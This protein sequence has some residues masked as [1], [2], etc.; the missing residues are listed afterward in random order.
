MDRSTTPGTDRSRALRDLLVVIAVVGFSFSLLVGTGVANALEG[1]LERTLGAAEDE[2]LLG[3]GLAALGLGVIAALRWREASDHVAARLAAEDRHQ[4][5]VEKI[6]A[7]TYTWNPSMG[8]DGT[9]VLYVSPQVEAILGFSVEDWTRDPELWK[10]QIH[11]DDRDAVLAESEHADRT[12]EPFAAEYRHRRPDGRYVWIHEEAL[13]VEHGPDGPTL[14][15]GVMYDVTERRRAEQRLREAEERYRTLVERVPAVTYVWDASHPDGRPM[16][17]VSPQ[18]EPLL[19]VE[20]EEWT[21]DAT[22]WSRNVHPDDLARVKREWN[23]ARERAV[24]FRAEYRIVRG[25]GSVAW[26]RDEAVPV[27]SD[28]EGMPTYQGVLLDITERKRAEERVREAEE[29]YRT[30]VEQLPAITYIED[31]SGRTT[32]ISPQIETMLG[33]APSEWVSSGDIWARQLHPDDRERVL[34]ADAEPYSPGQVFMVDYRIFAKDGRLVW[35]HN[36]A[37]PVLGPDGTPTA[38]QG[39]VLDI[40][41]QKDAESHLREAEERYRAIVEHIPGAVYVDVPDESMRSFYVSPQI[42][43]ILGVAPDAWIAQPDL[44]LEIMH[45]EDRAEAERS[46]TEAIEAGRAWSGEYRVLHPEGRWVWIHDEITFVRDDDGRPLF[47]Q[48]VMFDITERKRAEETLRSSERREREAAERLRALDEMKNTFLAAVSHE[49]RS[50]LTSILGLSLTLRNQDVA[51]Q[52]R[53]ELLERLAANARKLDRLLGDLLDIDR[54]KRGIVSPQYRVVDLDALVRRTVENLEL[55]DDRSIVL[56]LTPVTIL[57]DPAKLERI[58]ENLVVN[59]LRHTP[60]LATIW[61]RANP[62]PNGAIIAV[63]DDGPGVPADLRR[64]IFAPFRQGPTRSAHSPGT[65]IGLALVSMFAELHGG[66]AWVEERKGGG[67]SFRVE[68]PGRPP[69]DDAAPGSSPGVGAPDVAV[70]TG[71]AG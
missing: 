71:D 28:D 36:E 54:L 39:V 6:P 59:A 60:R 56:D 53:G 8:V 47:V 33:F 17:Y 9:R 64:E 25:D 3:F 58:V 20:P 30:L 4:A 42:R 22:G 35:L 1:W 48:G 57:A 41:A 12:G 19:G 52:E 23:G 32:Y 63:E 11:P 69:R 27:G 61:V 37:V 26:V 62:A 70:A 7:V 15:Q 2:V 68:L 65:G 14:V 13:A 67:A 29:R 34:A 21:R 50:P 18:I 5:V 10:R 49:L 44:W 45:P 24:A 51:A 66:R 38:W 40:T 46:Y 16:R 43:R 55:V 31:A